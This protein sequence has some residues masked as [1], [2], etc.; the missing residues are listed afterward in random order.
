RQLLLCRHQLG[1]QRIGNR[2]LTC[3]GGILALYAAQISR[4]VLQ[5]LPLPLQLVGPALQLTL[6]VI[7]FTLNDLKLLLQVLQLCLQT[8]ATLLY[9]HRTGVIREDEHENDRAEATADTVEERQTEDF[10]TATPAH[11]FRASPSRVSG[12]CRWSDAR[13][14]RTDARPADRPAW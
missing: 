6:E 4:K 7:R 2:R 14:S 1:F 8:D 5:L 12:W 13:D 11:G 3:A 9:L 10:D